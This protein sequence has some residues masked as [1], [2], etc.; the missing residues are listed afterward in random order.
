MLKY[1]ILVIFICLHCL[2]F[3]QNKSQIFQVIVDTDCGIDDQRALAMLLTNKFINVEA[4][5]TS[6]GNM[7]PVEGVTKIK[8]MLKELNF[9]NIPVGFGSKSL[10]K[11]PEWRNF[12]QSL[13]WGT[14]ASTNTSATDAL[15]LLQKKLLD[16]KQPLIY[17]CLGPLS[18]LANLQEKKPEALKMIQKVI[19]YNKQVYPTAGFNYEADQKAADQFIKSKIRVDVISNL[20]VQSAVIDEKLSTIIYTSTTPISTYLSKIYKSDIFVKANHTM[21]Q[22]F[23]DDLTVIY[24]L[25]PELFDLNVKPQNIYLHYTTGFNVN[26]IKEVFYD[27]FSG[28][29]QLE[30]NIVFNVFPNNREMFN[31]DVRQVM[32]SI[33]MLYGKEEWK[34]CVMTDEFHGHLG[35]FSIVGAKM[36]IRAREFFG[37]GPDQME[38]ISFAGLKPP[39]S[40]LNDGLQVSTGATLGRGTIQISADSITRTEAIF[41]CKGR[42]IKLSLKHEYVEQSD[43]DIKD[44]LLKYGLMDEGYWKLVRRNAIKYWKEWDRN[45]IFDVVEM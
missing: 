42:K 31:Y 15:T 18:N 21:T 20:S 16:S 45:K 5:V 19:W 43:A 24:L 23:V 33:L 3:S 4:I 38:V 8:A 7:D 11:T 30:K 13:P 12:C 6:D 35:I 29:Y 44:G 1:S 37:V 36:G 34:A 10:I 39:Y 40:C 14:S 32:D 2:L 41:I 9:E 17:I 25:N 22:K 28:E 27:L 26:A